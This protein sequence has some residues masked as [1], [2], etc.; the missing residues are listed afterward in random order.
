MGVGYRLPQSCPQRRAHQPR[1]GASRHSLRLG[2]HRLALLAVLTLTGCA[3]GVTLAIRTDGP[4]ALTYTILRNR[5]NTGGGRVMLVNN[6]HARVDLTWPAEDGLDLRDL[7]S[8][9]VHVR[10]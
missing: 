4:A 5:K 7:A 9:L 10:Q 2:S 3:P 1:R 6:G 8:E